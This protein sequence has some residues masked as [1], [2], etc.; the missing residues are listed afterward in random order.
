MVGMVDWATLGP[1]V[2]ECSDKATYSCLVV[3]LTGSSS[4]LEGVVH[5]QSL[6]KVLG[7]AYSEL[8]RHIDKL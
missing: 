4:Y 8:N 5:E 2:A 3:Q 1:L 7:F 6:K